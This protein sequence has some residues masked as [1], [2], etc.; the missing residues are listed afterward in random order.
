VTINRV[1]LFDRTSVMEFEVGEGNLGDHRIRLSNQPGQFSEQERR[2]IKVNA[3]PLDEVIGEIS[4]P[5]AVKIH[6]Q[7]AEPFVIG[8]GRQT[9]P[10]FSF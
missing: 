7:G 5:L 4:G 2:V 6:T 1:A 3:A 9:L 8:G 10:D